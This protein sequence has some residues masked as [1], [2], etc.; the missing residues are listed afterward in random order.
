MRSLIGTI[1]NQD[2]NIA[3][4]DTTDKASQRQHPGAHDIAESDPKVG[5][6]ILMNADA[7]GLSCHSILGQLPQCLWT[8]VCDALLL[9]VADTTSRVV[10]LLSRRQDGE[11]TALRTVII[12]TADTRLS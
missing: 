6:R 11:P 2:A 5:M 8:L 7:A 9:H 10:L 4:Y 1:T 3:I 12:N